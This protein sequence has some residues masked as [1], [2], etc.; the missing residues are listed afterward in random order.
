MRKEVIKN[1][2]KVILKL[3]YT[4]KCFKKSIAIRR[5]KKVW[6]PYDDSKMATKNGFD[7]STMT[8]I[9]ASHLMAAQFIHYCL[10]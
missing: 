4:L 5:P 1:E 7:Q 9:I 6:S 10:W 3:I 2:S 8:K